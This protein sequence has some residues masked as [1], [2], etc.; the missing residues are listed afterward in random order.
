MTWSFER[1]TRARLE[2]A[3]WS[4]IECLA[5][6][7]LTALVLA[8]AVPSVSS[9]LASVRLRAAAIQVG[10]A[11]ARVRSGALAEGR[12]FE[13][14]VVGEDGLELGAVG[15]APARE[16]LPRGVVFAGATSGGAVRVSAAG[17]AENA[18]FTLA[19]GG[20][21]RRVT[22]NQRGRITIE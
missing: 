12:P 17:V 16:R 22:L 10:A 1:P 3:G 11:L 4:L 21:E 2:P 19:I 20:L 5:G 18:T 8:V 6:L 9:A 13:L 7:A 15:G 14:R